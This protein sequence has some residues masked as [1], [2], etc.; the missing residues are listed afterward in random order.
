MARGRMGL[1]CC[2]TAGGPMGLAH[3]PALGRMRALAV[4]LVGG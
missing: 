4:G 3:R 1:M 2:A